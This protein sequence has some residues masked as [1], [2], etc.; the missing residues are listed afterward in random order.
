MTMSIA[1][2][3]REILQVS[4]LEKILQVIMSFAH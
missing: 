1:H 3:N 4:A 2:S